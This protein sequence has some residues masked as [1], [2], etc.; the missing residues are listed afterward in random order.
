MKNTRRIVAGRPAAHTVEFAIVSLVF[1]VVILGI[2]EM[3]RVLM[4][5][6]LLEEAARRGCRTVVIEGTSNTDAQTAIDNYLPTSGVNGYTMT[7]L[8]NDVVAN[9]STANSDDEVTVKVSVPIS[10]VTWIPG[11]TYFFSGTLTEQS[12]LRRE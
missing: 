2:V 6:H 11:N 4:V 5:C 3:C 1:F 10:S 12:T 8:V 7:V 9:A